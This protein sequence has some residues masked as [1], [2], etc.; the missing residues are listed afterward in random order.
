[1]STAFS[2]F[3]P[4]VTYLIIFSLQLITHRVTLQVDVNLLLAGKDL[5]KPSSIS[6]PHTLLG[7]YDDL[8]VAPPVTKANIS[9][10]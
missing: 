9:I 2:N 10:L 3:F 4:T 6:D 8:K 7:F 5:S 1:L